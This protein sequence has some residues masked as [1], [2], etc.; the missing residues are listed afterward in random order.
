MRTE[1]TK[2]L[3]ALLDA[4]QNL[5]GRNYDLC[6]AAHDSWSSKAAK[7]YLGF[8]LHIMDVTASPWC[9]VVKTL[10]C[11][12]HASPH[13]AARNL[14]KAKQILDDWNLDVSVLLAVTQDTTGNSIGT[15]PCSRVS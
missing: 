12:H 7:S 13:T 14:D 8:N 9:I 2:N 10:A 15:S 5:C 3:H 4:L 1:E 6:S 11:A